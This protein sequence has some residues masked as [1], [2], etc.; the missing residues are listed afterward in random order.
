MIN[1]LTHA[2]IDVSFI[3]KTDCIGMMDDIGTIDYSN[4]L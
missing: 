1:L 4:V 3:R 2:L